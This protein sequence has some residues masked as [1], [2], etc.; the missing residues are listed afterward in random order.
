MKG[1]KRQVTE[2]MEQSNHERIKTLGEKNDYEYVGILKA[3]TI[4]Q[5]EVKDKK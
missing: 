3:D 2:G 5:V 1:G 4:K